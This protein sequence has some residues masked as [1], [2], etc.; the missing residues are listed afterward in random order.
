MSKLST[1]LFRIY[2]LDLL[3]AVAAQHFTFSTKIKKISWFVVHNQL[4]SIIYFKGKD[5]KRTLWND[6]ED[7][8]WYHFVKIL[9]Y[10]VNNTLK[11]LPKLHHILR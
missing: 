4:K 9:Q 1:Y 6:G 10:D 3:S 2:F 7:I 8:L 5:G 11:F